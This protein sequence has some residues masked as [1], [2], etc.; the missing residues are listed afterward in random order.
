MM[1]ICHESPA[2]HT[3]QFA[4]Q[5]EQQAPECGTGGKDPCRN[6]GHSALLTANAQRQRLN[7]RLHAGCQYSDGGVPERPHEADA[8]PQGGI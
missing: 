8:G 1:S 2:R 5:A 7:E 6:C 4:C 3:R